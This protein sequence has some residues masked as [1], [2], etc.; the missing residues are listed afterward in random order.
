[1]IATAGQEGAAKLW[2]PV[3]GE[4][5]STLPRESNHLTQVL[6]DSPR[7][8]LLGCDASVQLQVWPTAEVEVDANQSESATQ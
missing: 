5:R 3:T 7:H 6:F 4:E 2:D 8:R 1:V